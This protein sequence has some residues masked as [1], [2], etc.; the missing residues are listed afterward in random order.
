[1]TSGVNKALYQTTSSNTINA[2]KEKLLA[3]NSLL[4]TSNIR[5]SNA[6][7][8][9]GL[10]DPS[11]REF[12]PSTGKSKPEE[13]NPMPAADIPEV[14]GAPE[15]LKAAVMRLA[16]DVTAGMKV[17]QE[18]LNRKLLFDMNALK[19]ER[20]S[21]KKALEAEKRARLDAENNLE[22][23]KQRVLEEVKDSENQ[24]LEHAREMQKRNAEVA[25][26]RE[27]LERERRNDAE[28]IASLTREQEEL[29]AK[30][31]ESQLQINQGSASA[32]ALASNL[33][34]KI[35]QE[36]ARHEETKEK[37]RK[38]EQYIEERTKSSAALNEKLQKEL[39]LALTEK[40][41]LE[42]NLEK[43]PQIASQ[44]KPSMPPA[45]HKSILDSGL[46][47]LVE[48]MPA[49]LSASTEQLVLSPEQQTVARALVKGVLAYQATQEGNGGSAGHDRPRV[50]V[51]S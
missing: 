5:T 38:R 25:S 36:Q 20:D 17:E 14:N 42:E 29:R 43:A 28:A 8:P 4:S 50:V 47:Y 15:W 31:K 3:S 39:N 24:E 51:W 16:S 41:A 34:E 35:S 6:F 37:L 27:Q 1:M 30:L 12:V 33:G 18:A 21:A 45:G 26:L 19:L 13:T 11:A 23:L 22:Q 46:K 2:V 44:P 40:K 10:L 48:Q 7:P 32:A 49:F 9:V